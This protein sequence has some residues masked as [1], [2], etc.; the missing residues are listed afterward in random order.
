MARKIGNP[1]NFGPI[2]IDGTTQ[3]HHRQF[4]RALTR[5]FIFPGVN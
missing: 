4:T 5:G 2:D 3:G 1:Q